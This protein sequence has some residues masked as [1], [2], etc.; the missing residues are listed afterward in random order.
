MRYYTYNGNTVILTENQ[1]NQILKRFNEKELTKYK[2]YKRGVIEARCPLCDDYLMKNC[3]GCPFEVFGK[4]GC[5]NHLKELYPNDPT[6]HI[7][8][9]HFV[10]INYSKDYKIFKSIK[11]IFIKAKKY[12]RMRDIRREIEK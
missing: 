4:F 2:T 5:I 8:G 1:Y 7:F 9:K 3:K 6:E 10:N 12:S 11:N